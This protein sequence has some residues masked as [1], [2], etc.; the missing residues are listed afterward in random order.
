MTGRRDW[1]VGSDTAWRPCNIDHHTALLGYLES[2]RGLDGVG[3][4]FAMKFDFFENPFF[5]QV[6]L[7]LLSW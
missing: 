6:A 1:S 7:Y 4:A 5:F 3:G 2:I